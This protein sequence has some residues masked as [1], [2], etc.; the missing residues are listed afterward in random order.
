MDSLTADVIRCAAWVV[1]FARLD[2][3]IDRLEADLDGDQ[4]VA[5]RMVPV[6]LHDY[7]SWADAFCRR[8]PGTRLLACLQTSS[9]SSERTSQSVWWPSLWKWSAKLIHCSPYA[10]S[11]AHVPRD[12]GRRILH[13]TRPAPPGGAPLGR[14]IRLPDPAGRVRAA[15]AARSLYAGAARSD[16]HVGRACPRIR[17]RRKRSRETAMTIAHAALPRMPPQNARE[18]R[19][20]LHCVQAPEVGSD[21]YTTQRRHDYEERR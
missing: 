17:G 5:A 8:Q 16:R 21:I 4:V 1:A 9:R 12:R 14:P 18:H 7:G 6:G 10:E 11:A 19:V 13:Q 20:G 3:E 2:L 15:G